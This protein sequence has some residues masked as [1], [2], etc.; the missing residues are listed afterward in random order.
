M[1]S[2]ARDHQSVPYKRGNDDT[3]DHH[4]LDTRPNDVDRL[5]NVPRNGKRVVDARVERL[6][7]AVD[8]G[9]RG[10]PAYRSV[11]VLVRWLTDFHSNTNRL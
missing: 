6:R 10:E 4:A 5:I 11:H 2:H 8:A 9:N 3:D 7:E 1:P